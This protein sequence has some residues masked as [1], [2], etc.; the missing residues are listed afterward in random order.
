MLNMGVGM[1]L[2]VA[3]RDVAAVQSM[4]DEPTWLIGRLIGGEPGHRRVH[5]V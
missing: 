4:I 1:V 5:L 3:E 2:V